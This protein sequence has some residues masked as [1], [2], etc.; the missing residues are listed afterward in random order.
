[1]PNEN[2][3]AAAVVA[4][5]VFSVLLGVAFWV[6]VIYTAVHFIYKV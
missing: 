6:G 2:K 3:L 5:W 1:M 4:V